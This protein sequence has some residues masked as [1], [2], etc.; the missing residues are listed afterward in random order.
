M[1]VKLTP[2][3]L[4]WLWELSRNLIDYL[5]NKIRAKMQVFKKSVNSY[6]Q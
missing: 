5:E 1:S 6:N 3:Q 4:S 2:W